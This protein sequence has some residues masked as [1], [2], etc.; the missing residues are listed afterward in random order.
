MSELGGGQWKARMSG[1]AN[2]NVPRRKKTGSVKEGV[3]EL[4]PESVGSDLRR[5]DAW[6]TRDTSDGNRRKVSFGPRWR[7]PRRLG[8]ESSYARAGLPPPQARASARLAR[9][10]TSRRALP[11]HQKYSPCVRRPAPMLGPL[12]YTDPLKDAPGSVAATSPRVWGGIETFCVLDLESWDALTLLSTRLVRVD[13]TALCARVRECGGATTWFTRHPVNTVVNEI[14]REWKKTRSVFY[15]EDRFFFL[16]LW[17]VELLTWHLKDR[18]REL[19]I[20]Y[21]T[22]WFCVSREMLYP[23]FLLAM[24]NIRWAL[25]WTQ[26]Q[27]GTNSFKPHNNL[28]RQI[29]IL[30]TICILWNRGTE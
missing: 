25:T 21:W 29:I 17:T 27:V 18:V 22:Y 10:G 14:E 1:P 9:A 4:S 5:R 26:F 8:V 28:M 16:K 30:L 6:A 13:Y 19:K 2:L 12:R 11:L 23:I 7:R 3:G 15:Q 20:V 24:S